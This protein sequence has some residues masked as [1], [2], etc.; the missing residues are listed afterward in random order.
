MF[1]IFQIPI[2]VDDVA[3]SLA[4]AMAAAI[5]INL[6]LPST[7]RA[8]KLRM[9]CCQP[10]VRVAPDLQMLWAAGFMVGEK[11]GVKLAP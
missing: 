7:P 2:D 4:L 6:C 9:L 8:S 3:E 10:D 11:P 1:T 5:L